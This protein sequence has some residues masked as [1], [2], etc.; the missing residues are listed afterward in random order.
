MNQAGRKHTHAHHRG[1]H[2]Q[3]PTKGLKT[4]NTQQTGRRPA[5]PRHT[6]AP[7]N[8]APT[9]RPRRQPHRRAAGPTPHRRPKP[10]TRP[11]R[12]TRSR[13]NPYTGRRGRSTQ[14][15]VPHIPMK[16]SDGGRRIRKATNPISQSQRPAPEPRTRAEPNHTET[17]PPQRLT[18]QSDAWWP[19]RGN[20]SS[21][22]TARPERTGFPIR[23]T[24]T[25]LCMC[26]FSRVPG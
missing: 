25:C 3:T 2:E 15:H 23:R 20:K 4:Q 8:G 19:V 12:P 13:P 5:A 14:T 18:P 9:Q 21:V 6:P 11:A 10:L 24:I 17:S 1:T 22:G 7:E 16:R 26:V